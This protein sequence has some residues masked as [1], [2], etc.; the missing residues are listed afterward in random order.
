MKL[1]SKQHEDLPDATEVLA[2]SETMAASAGVTARKFFKQQ[3]E[4]EFKS[5]ESPVT[6]I[7][8][9]IERDLKEAITARFPGDAIFGEESGVDG[10]L[11]GNLWVIDP[12]DGT[13]SFISGNPLFGMLLS[14]LRGGEPLVGTISMPMLGEVYSGANGCTATC[15]G[16]P[17]RV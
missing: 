17:I 5:D 4:T 3:N 7:D 16:E 10:N 6:I 8:Q 9:M 14:Y 15:N 1:S 2:F 11:D 13:R 12:I